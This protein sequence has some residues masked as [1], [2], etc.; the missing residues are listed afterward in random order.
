MANKATFKQK[1]H[2]GPPRGEPWC[3]NTA[4]RLASKAW[5]GRSR[6]CIRLIDRLELEHMA[7]AG[8]ENGRLPVSYE[9]FVEFGI[10]RRFI[11]PAI[12]EAVDRGFI[13]V[14]F[15]GLKL[16]DAPNRYRL[17]YYATSKKNDFGAYEWSAPTD[18]WK[19]CEKRF[20]SSP[21]CRKRGEKLHKGELTGGSLAVA[22][23][24]KVA[25]N[26]DIVPP[27]AVSKGEPSNIYAS[28]VPARRP[29]SGGGH[30]GTAQPT[31]SLDRTPGSRPAFASAP[32]EQPD[33]PTLTPGEKSGGA[34]RVKSATP[35]A[36]NTEVIDPGEP[37]LFPSLPEQRSE[38]AE[39]EAEA[40]AAL[41][42]RYAEVV[43]AAPPR[44]RERFAIAIRSSPSHLS[45][46]RSGTWPLGA[47]HQAELRRL[48]DT[49]E[50]R[51][52]PNPP[53]R[54][55]RHAAA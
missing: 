42:A 2:A 16:K 32:V 6:N 49:G 27:P 46:W 50:W 22:P 28:P 38:S 15:H 24:E 14:T 52:L 1:H 8:K 43:D 11:S 39:Q 35:P 21:L 10:G 7:H 34:S 30:F 4:E 25:E 36:A 45:N 33:R 26:L 31:P 51:D 48:I 47:D 20:S 53:P 3:W 44:T 19:A 18:E 55:K 9:Q 54:K 41:L 29:R 37:M 13:E 40:E 23:A 17:T 5:Q 12:E